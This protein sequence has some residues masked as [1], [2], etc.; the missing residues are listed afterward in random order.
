MQPI[1][2]LQLS[3]VHLDSRLQARRLGLSE[4]RR[5]ER[6]HE[7]LETFFTAVQDALHRGVDAVLI[8]GD[9]FEGESVTGPTVSFLIDAFNR[10]APTPVFIA[11]GN[12]DWFSATSLYNGRVVAARGLPQW[13]AN[14]HIFDSEQF[15]TVKHPQRPEISFTGRAFTS[16]EAVAQRLLS[17][18]L[19]RDDQAQVNVLLFHGFLE[20]YQGPDASHP[21]KYSCPFSVEELEAQRFTYSALGHCHEFAEVYSNQGELIGAYSGSLVGRS[22]EEVGVRVALYVNLSTAPDGRMAV[23][24]EPVEYDRR[25][26]LIAAADISGLGEEDMLQE[27]SLSIEDQGAREKDIVYLHLEGGYPPQAD[28]QLVVEKLKETYFQVYLADNTRPDYLGERFDERTTEW[29]YIEAMLEL[30]KNAERNPNGADVAAVDHEEL[31]GKTVEDALYYGLDA[32]RQQ[33][34]RIKDVD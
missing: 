20:G 32:L 5:Y 16:D 13:P 11:P 10:I 8:P 3:D 25:R 15:T 23:A 6:N 34:V 14:V 9:L 27:I 30:K 22:F 18:G 1:K 28:P 21:E 31:S 12:R 33:K 2:F 17:Q 24:L 4:T 7:I 29:K 26:I 19:P